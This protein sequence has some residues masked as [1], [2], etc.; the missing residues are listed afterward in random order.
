MN[1]RR[2]E[3]IQVPHMSKRKNKRKKEENKK[4]KKK[5]IE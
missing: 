2:G 1:K 5:K 4:N 3:K